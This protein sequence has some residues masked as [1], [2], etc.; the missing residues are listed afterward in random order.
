MANRMGTRSWLTGRVALALLAGALLAACNLGQT[1]PS[2]PTDLTPGFLLP[3][4]LE[5]TET[6]IIQ[7]PPTDTPMPELLPSE[8]LGPISIDGTTHRATEAATVRVRS[9][10]AV[11]NVVCTWA[12][13]DTGQSAQL[14][15][16]ATNSVDENTNEL[17]YTFTPELAGTYSVSCTGVSLTA[18]GQRAVS[19]AGSPFS[20]EAKG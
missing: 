2:E 6:P 17:V 10:T 15:T 14:G 16:P 1:A 4:D 9:G 3:Q 13:Q 20:V 8:A 12:H 7:L 5:V 11:S 18:E 19:A